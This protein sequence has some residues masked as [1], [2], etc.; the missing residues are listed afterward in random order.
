MRTQ[1]YNEDVPSKRIDLLNNLIGL[2]LNKLIRYS[3]WNGEKNITELGIKP[4]QVFS[5]CGGPVLCHFNTGLI[6]GASSDSSRSSIIIW[7]EKNELGD[8]CDDS[9][10]E[11]TE[12]VPISAEDNQFSDGVWKQVLGK[13]ISNVQILKRIPKNIKYAD[14]ENEVGLLIT[15][16]NEM[17]FVLSHGL[18]DNSGDFSV[19]LEQQINSDILQQ[20]YVL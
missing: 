20:L 5:N 11:D 2:T 12:Y 13:K 16:E 9:I 10:E 1:M 4:N 15:M 17:R 8:V 14:L 18:H 3:W 19:I 6:I 7:V